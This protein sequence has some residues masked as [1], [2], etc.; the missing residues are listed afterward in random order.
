[1]LSKLKENLKVIPNWQQNKYLLAISGGVDSVVLAK[2]F[3]ELNLTFEL[4]HCNFKLRGAESDEDQQFVEALATDLQVPLHLKICDLSQTND[5]I[6]L[7]AREARYQWFR[8]LK[9]AKNFDFIVTAHHLD[10][11]IESFFLNLQRGTGLK[12]LLGIQNTEEIL[13]PMLS[14][15]REEIEAFARYNKLNWR[16]DSSNQSDKY[17]RNFI[18][19]QIIPK[20]KA[21][22]PAFYQNF[23]KTFRFLNQSHAVVEDWFQLQSQQLIEKNNEVEKLA[24]ADLN[25][26][27]QPDLFLFHWLSPYGF[28]DFES[29]KKLLSTQTG[30]AVLSPTHSL[31]KHGDSLLLYTLS[32]AGNKAFEIQDFQQSIDEL[33]FEM[34]LIDKNDLSDEVLFSAS[35]NEAFID[36][37]LLQWP[38][39][40]RTWQAGD[41]FH[42]LG[43]T[44]KKKISDYLTDVKIPKPEKEKIYLLCNRNEVVWL[45]GHRLDNRYK[46]RPQTR[47]I[48][49][50]VL[51]Q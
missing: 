38:L 28:R 17:Q 48:L 9:S 46:V 24:I 32:S 26:I 14:V 8:D 18:R 47:Q 41:Y 39:N 22:Q 33:P 50:I 31:T 13:R 1:M 6:Q 23:L 25:H 36:Y 34:Q 27:K 19:H 30:K 20:L 21:N 15:P 44:G 12:G 3:K 7:A 35:K 42:P 40:I 2:A 4:A 5:N 49:H 37:D 10:D 29:I 16:E 43:M 51:K 11:S 45:I